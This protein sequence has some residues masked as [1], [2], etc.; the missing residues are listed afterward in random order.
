MGYAMG[1]NPVG[2]VV[3]CHRVVTSSGKP[4]NYC[5]GR[6]N[7]LKAWLLEHERQEETRG[8]KVL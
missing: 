3:P 5:R 1:H 7:W 8:V 4:G 6:R 2:L